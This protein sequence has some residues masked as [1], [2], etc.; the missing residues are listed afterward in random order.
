MARFNRYLPGI[1]SLA[2]LVLLSCT[3]GSAALAASA[4][5][6]D[7]KVD[8]SI[9]RFRTEVGGGAAFLQKAEGVLVF[10]NVVK[11]GFWVG[12]GIR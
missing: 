11:A 3:C 12:G 5:E 4:E 7:L 6:I 10:P 1:L 2:T 8:A 9:E